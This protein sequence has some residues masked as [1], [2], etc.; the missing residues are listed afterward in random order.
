MKSDSPVC[1]RLGILREHRRR[2][3]SIHMA[4]G[5]LMIYLYLLY[6]RYHINELTNLD[7]VVRFNK[8]RNCSRSD[9]VR[10]DDA[11][12]NIVWDASL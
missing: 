8:L 11:T 12:E 6:Y 5:R 2:Y 10:G 9:L 3:N 7:A 4:Y 1:T